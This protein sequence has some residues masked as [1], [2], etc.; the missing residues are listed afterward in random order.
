VVVLLLLGFITPLFADDASMIPENVIRFRVIP[1]ATFQS[2]TFDKDGDREDIAAYDSATVYDLSF[3]LEY[4]IV[5]WITAA[6]QWTPGWRFASSFDN[7]ENIPGQQLDD[8]GVPANFIP[9]NENLT[10]KGLN[11]LFVGAKFQIVG[12]NAPVPNEQHRFAIAAGT[13]VPLTNYDAEAEAENYIDEEDYRPQRVDNDAWGAGFRLYYDYVVSESFF[14]NLYNETIIYFPTDQEQFGLDFDPP[15]FEVV[16]DIDEVEVNYGYDVTF[17]I[18][19]QYQTMLSDS[20]RFGAGLPITYSMSPELEVDG[21]S[22]EDS[23]S[24]SLYVGPNVSL[25][26]FGG[27]WPIDLELGVLVPVLGKNVDASTSVVLQIKN[28]LRFW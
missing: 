12:E 10:S 28:Y 4:G 18:E 3:A 23:D 14:I 15:P 24:Y 20:L 6:L 22:V 9:D 25:F 5:D 7:P 13:I 27:P 19:P 16:P 21:E 26:L 17:E 2:K 11:D 1:S 8:A